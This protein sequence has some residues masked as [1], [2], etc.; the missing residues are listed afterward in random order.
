MAVVS[1]SFYQCPRYVLHYFICVAQLNILKWQ[2]V[3][4]KYKYIDELINYDH[5]YPIALEKNTGR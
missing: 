2:Y 4:P 1:S 3:A 5:A